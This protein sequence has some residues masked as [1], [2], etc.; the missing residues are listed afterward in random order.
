M[1]AAVLVI[2]IVNDTFAH[3][4]KISRNTRAVLPD[5]N[6]FLGA[7]RQAGA[8]IIFSTDSFLEDDFFFQGRM[9]PHSIRGTKGAEP[10]EELDRK[11][12]DVWLPKRRFSAFFKTD[13]DQTLRWWGVDTV[14]VCGVAVHVCVLATAFEAVCLDFKTVILEDLSVAPTPEFHQRT[15][16]NY[17]RFPLEPNF[18]VL[19]ATDFLKELQND[20]KT[21]G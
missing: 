20:D 6:R 16:D 13:L 1:K 18:R 17:R 10:A 15:L 21:G 11:P 19:T 4:N 3:D 9:K 14:A 12:E 8:K 5:L 7:A 2:D